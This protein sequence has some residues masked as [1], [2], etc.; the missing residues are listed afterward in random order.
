MLLTTLLFSML[1]GLPVLERP[2]LT[3]P[4]GYIESN[5]NSKARGRAGEKG[6]WQVIEKHWGKV[7]KD[8]L[9]QALQSERIMNELLQ[10]SNGNLFVAMRKYNGTGVAAVRY[11]KTLRK[12]SFESALMRV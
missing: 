12:R 5:M 7:P 6:A 8:L 3:V 11:A 2:H 10:D 4:Q 9:G 1:V